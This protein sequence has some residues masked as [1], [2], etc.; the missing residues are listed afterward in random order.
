LIADDDLLAWLNYHLD[1]AGYGKEI[2]NFTDDLKDGTAYVA[3]MNRLDPH[4]CD[5]SP[6]EKEGE[7]RAQG[8]INNGEA[9]GV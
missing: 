8:I 9:M 1:K 4:N 7:E 2:K 6:L 5:K 3:L